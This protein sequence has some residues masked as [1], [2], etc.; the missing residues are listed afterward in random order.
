[1]NSLGKKK[2]ISSIWRLSQA[3]EEN[4]HKLSD[5]V[6]YYAACFEDFHPVNYG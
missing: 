6:Q 3:L 1:M 2:N 4:E 5:C